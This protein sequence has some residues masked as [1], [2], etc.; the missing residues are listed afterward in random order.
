MLARCGALF[1]IG[2]DEVAS[3]GKPSWCWHA[4]VTNSLAQADASRIDRIAELV[5]A[6][7]ELAT[8]KRSPRR[9]IDRIAELVLAQRQRLLEAHE[10]LRRIDRKAELVLAP[11]SV[12]T[13][14]KVP[15]R[16]HRPDSRVGV[17]TKLKAL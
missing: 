4:D 6:L 8:G 2:R 13:E 1:G 17:G 14:I 9:R 11:I 12:L 16:S 7:K 15:Q 10:Q 5:L 3:T